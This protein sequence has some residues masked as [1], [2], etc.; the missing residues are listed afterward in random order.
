[1]AE[2]DDWESKIIWGPGSCVSFPFH[3]LP[4][5][6]DPTSG[7]RKHPNFSDPILLAPRNSEFERGDWVKSIIWDRGS[8]YRDFTALNLNL[9]DPQMLLEMQAKGSTGTPRSCLPGISFFH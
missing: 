5:Q 8:S 1:M 9:N 3:A 2:L 7:R 4:S 6:A